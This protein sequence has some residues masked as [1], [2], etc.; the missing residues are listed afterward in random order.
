MPTLEKVLGRMLISDRLFVKSVYESTAEALQIDGMLD[1]PAVTTVEDVMEIH[2]SVK[3]FTQ[4]GI[5]TQCPE[6]FPL[7]D[8]AVGDALIDAV[9]EP[10]NSDIRKKV[11]KCFDRI[12]WAGL[13]GDE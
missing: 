8:V 12:A 7:I 11:V 10:L 5:R 4:N 13:G 3:R 2:S 1:D 6:L 9:D